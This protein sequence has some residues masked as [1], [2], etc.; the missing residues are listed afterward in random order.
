[1]IGLPAHP[2]FCR[3]NIVAEFFQVFFDC[4]PRKFLAVGNLSGIDKNIGAE[5]FHYIDYS[6]FDL[7]A[8]SV[9]FIAETKIHLLLQ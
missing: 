6:H 9:W 3:R 2:Y 1:M 5:F 4:C 7:V 8:N